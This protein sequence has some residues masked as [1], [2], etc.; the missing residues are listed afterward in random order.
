MTI[1]SGPVYE[2]I[3]N[4]FYNMT[5]SS[6]GAASLATALVAMTSESG[7]NPLAVLQQLNQATSTNQIKQIL[8]AVFNAGLPSMANLGFAKS[9][10][11]NPWVSRNI[12]P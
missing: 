4:Y 5:G 2:E 10:T 1:S 9:S 11:Q 8:I 12:L 3:Y 7:A 6:A